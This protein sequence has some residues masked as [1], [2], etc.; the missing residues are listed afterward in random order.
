MTKR[1][2]GIVNYLVGKILAE[3]PSLN[4]RNVKEAVIRVL[5]KEKEKK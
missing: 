3:N 4:P 2:K 1:Q 5:D